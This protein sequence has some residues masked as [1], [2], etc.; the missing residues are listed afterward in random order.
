MS[1][2]GFFPS[3]V[4]GTLA[5]ALKDPA[6][7]LAPLLVDEPVKNSFSGVQYGIHLALF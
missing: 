2:K 1:F 3:K 7:E 5:M 6:A 4:R